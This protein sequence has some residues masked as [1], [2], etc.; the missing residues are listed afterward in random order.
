M[1]TIIE[2]EEKHFTNHVKELDVLINYVHKIR[3]LVSLD[4]EMIFH[5][6]NM[7]NEEKME[8]ILALNEVVK[9]LISL[10]E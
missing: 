8:I 5:I 10:L 6:R 3:D 2:N 7:Q 1:E 9:S 4:E